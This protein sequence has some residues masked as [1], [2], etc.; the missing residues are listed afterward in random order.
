MPHNSP[1]RLVLCHDFERIELT[2]PFVVDR[3]L[4][5]QEPRGQELT[6]CPEGRGPAGPR[7]SDYD[8]DALYHPPSER[9]LLTC[10]GVGRPFGALGTPATASSR[11][12]RSPDSRP[13][14]PASQRGFGATCKVRVARIAQATD[15]TRSP[16]PSAS[17]GTRQSSPSFSGFFRSLLSAGLAVAECRDHRSEGERM[18]GLRYSIESPHPQRSGKR[19][20]SWL[21]IATVPRS[22]TRS[23]AMAGGARP[24]EDGVGSPGRHPREER[25]GGR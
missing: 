9:I 24:N 21:S 13:W 3:R 11:R 25:H 16:R 15:Q 17:R 14:R 5:G 12:G 19:C 6:A 10:A 8:Q 18:P 23:G 7:H 22:G 4:F 1:V 20:A 2:E